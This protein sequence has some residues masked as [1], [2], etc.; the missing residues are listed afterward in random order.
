MNDLSYNVITSISS[1]LEPVPTAVNSTF[2]KTM[3]PLAPTVFDADIAVNPAVL[4]LLNAA[5]T[6]SELSVTSVTCTTDGS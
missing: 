6:E 4:S 2:A 1:G 5:V 3:S